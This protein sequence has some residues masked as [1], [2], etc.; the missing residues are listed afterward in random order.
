MLCQPIAVKQSISVNQSLEIS[1]W[2]KTGVINNFTALCRISKT[3]DWQIPRRTTPYNS[4]WLYNH[5]QVWPPHFPIPK[6]SS[7]LTH[8]CINAYG[9][10]FFIF[11]SF[12]FW[13]MN[14]VLGLLQCIWC[15]SWVY[16]IEKKFWKCATRGSR[17]LSLYGKPHSACLT[18]RDQKK[19][20]KNNQKWS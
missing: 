18:W 5:N 10:Q 11:F 12:F 3:S 8:C 6:L 20:K 15:V 7:L 4:T 19:Q 1:P 16:R 13:L 17:N 2:K 9:K 14:L